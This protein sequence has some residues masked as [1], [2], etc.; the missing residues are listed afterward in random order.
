MGKNEACVN[1]NVP[2]D[3]PLSLR[4][5]VHATIADYIRTQEQQIFDLVDAFGS[6]LNMIFPQIIEENIAAF[7]A[8]Y[9]KHHLQG[10]IYYTTKPNKAQAILRQAAL[11]DVG[12]DVSSE[13]SLKA[14]LQA[15]FHPSRIECTGPKNKA[16]L[17]LAIQQ[18][19]TINAD[20]MQEL[21]QILQIRK[22]LNI[23][24]KVRCFVRLSGFSSARMKFTPQ[25]GT[26]GIHV[27][28]APAIFTFLE[29]HKNALDFQGFS[30][31]FNAAVSEQKL[32]AIETLLT[33]TIEAGQRG[34]SPKGIN[35]GG[36]F[37]IC[38]AAD[39]QEWLDYV[40]QL[41]E[42]LRDYGGESLNWNNSG[43]GFR[44]E[45][46]LIKGAPN[47]MA[48]HID[49]TG[50]DDLDFY[51]CKP[52]AGFDGM[53]AAQ[54]LADCLLALYIEPGRA[55]L[56]QLGVTVARV[57]FNKTSMHGETL[58][59][60]DM[61]RSNMHSTHQKLLTDP[62]ILTRDRAAR[63]PCPQGVYYTGNLCLSYDMITYNKTF[64]DFCP[65]E[66]DL[67]IFIN[68]APYI[69]DFV[70]SRTLHQNIAEK[71]AVTRKDGRFRWYRDALYNPAVIAADEQEKDNA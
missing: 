1:Q 45:G 7:R 5:R 57:N 49:R 43:L 12:A 11:Q 44:N 71:I 63:L 35:I 68:T 21:N 54:I 42:S 20:N 65:Q 37:D 33:L 19:A 14:A 55:L 70:E 28:D 53:S 36:G 46:G 23:A 47:F 27:D 8:V 39:K 59:G 13:G 10:R 6:P 2:G 24:D 41:K 25:D 38:Y 16:Y 61:N 22:A 9:Q 52:L 50:A 26:F 32:I 15:G 4:P 29:D 69:M 67:V 17:A 30:F 51:L 40:D 62:V 34:L 66:G 18:G 31:H 56:D 64:P 3:R 58:V 48:H 60:L